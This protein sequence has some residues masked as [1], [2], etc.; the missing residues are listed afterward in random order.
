MIST[1]K[2]KLDIKNM[3]ENAFY[4]KGTYCYY[5]GTEKGISMEYLADTLV[6][7]PAIVVFEQNDQFFLIFSHSLQQ[8]IHFKEDN[9]DKLV[10]ILKAS[11]MK[12]RCHSLYLFEHSKL[13]EHLTVPVRFIEH[14][15]LLLLSK[16]IPH[17]RTLTM[18]L[19]KVALLS[20]LV[21]VLCFAQSYVFEYLR[22]IANNE[23]RIETNKIKNQIEQAQKE[24]LKYQTM[25]SELPSET[26]QNYQEIIDEIAGVQK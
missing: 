14:K 3:N 1:V 15:K 16:K 18:Q 23:H 19:S 17:L 24:Y 5:I 25:L 12:T 20:V 26:A 22:D 4:L 7:E 13:A 2:Q 9:V 21:L 6:D 11:M 8:T 10:A